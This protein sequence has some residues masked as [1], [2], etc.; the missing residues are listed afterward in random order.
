MV[1][2]NHHKYHW[3][4]SITTQNAVNL[5]VKW[6]EIKSSLVFKVISES[7]QRSDESA[8]NYL[9]AK[10]SERRKHVCSENN[11]ERRRRRYTLSHVLLIC[12]NAPHAYRY[13]NHYANDLYNLYI[14]ACHCL[15]KKNPIQFKLP[16]SNC[17]FSGIAI[18]TDTPNPFHSL[19]LP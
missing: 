7:Y 3:M 18:K 13:T 9:V 14:F 8:W 2:T 16:L 11:Y 5:S 17:A 4:S 12:Q 1:I 15:P 6:I 19:Q 10:R